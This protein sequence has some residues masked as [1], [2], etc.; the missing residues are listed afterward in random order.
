M[1]EAAEKHDLT[2]N[3]DVAKV[4]CANLGTCCAGGDVDLEEI[5]SYTGIHSDQP[6]HDVFDKAGSQGDDCDE[7]SGR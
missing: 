6:Y 2:L 4:C 7:A 1:L 3:L 5:S